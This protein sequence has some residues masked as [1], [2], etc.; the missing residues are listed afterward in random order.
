MRFNIGDMFYEPP[1]PEL[2]I[3]IDKDKKRGYK[4]VN[5]FGE[6]NWLTAKYVNTLCA[7]VDK[8][9]MPTLTVPRRR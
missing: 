8:T 5:C 1:Y 2:R 9:P 3:I 4:A 6:V 7:H